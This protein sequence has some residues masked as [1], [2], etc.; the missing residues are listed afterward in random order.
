MK[1]ALICGVS[2]QDGAYLAKLLL[3][4]GYRVVGTSRDA[5]V[6]NFANLARLSI[7]DHV[8]ME[9]MALTDFRSTLQTIAKAK[10]DEVYNLAGQSSVALSFQQPVETMDSIC[11]GTL[12]LLEAVRFLGSEIRVYNASSSECFGD[13]GAEA[14]S[15]QTPFHPRSPYALAKAVAHYLLP[16]ASCSTMNLHSGRSALSRKRSFAPPVGFERAGKRLLSSVTSRSNEIGDGRRNTSRRCGAS[17]TGKGNFVPTEG[18]ATA[19][20]RCFCNSG[21]IRSRRR[22]RINA[23]GV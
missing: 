7:T 16:M 2:G 12:N 5:Q 14:A 8:E 3:E 19:R 6:A 1:T 23:G 13:T 21:A 11:V 17:I 4:K 15:E 18:T 20:V 22:S 9:S 10:P